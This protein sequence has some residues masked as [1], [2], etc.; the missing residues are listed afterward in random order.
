MTEKQIYEYSL[1]YYPYSNSPAWVQWFIKVAPLKVNRSLQILK[2][3]KKKNAKVLDFGCGIGFNIPFIASV[4]P[5]VVGID[6]DKPSV[7][8]AL[9]QLKKL[10]YDKKILH[11]NGE[12]LPFK[13]NSFDI[14]IANDVW[15]HTKD[16]RLMIKEIYRV[17]KPDGVF[18]I[19]TP[20][21]LW[22]IETHYKLPFLSYLPKQIANQYVQLMKKADSYDDIN[23]PTYN[24]FKKSVGEFFHLDNITFDLVKNYKK[25]KLDKERG[26][27]IPLL[28]NFLNFIEQDSRFSFFHRGIMEI[29]NTVSMGWFFVGHPKKKTLKNL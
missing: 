27:L 17:I 23:L 16:P 12:R 28:G 10:Q 9:K 2:R 6:T 13:K 26:L 20:N 19:N 18:L 1:F 4:F 8:I 25:N 24:T 22:P 11:Y 29:L 7:K 5:N 3:Y 21:K 15:E 14:V